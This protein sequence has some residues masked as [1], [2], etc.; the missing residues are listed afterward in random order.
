VD[1]AEGAALDAIGGI[2]GQEQPAAE[3][4]RQGSG[5]FGRVLVTLGALAGEDPEQIMEAVAGLTNLVDPAG[6]QQV[7]VD[8]RL[9]QLLGPLGGQVEQGPGHPGR[10]VGRVQHAQP[11]ERLLLE[12]REGA[13]AEGDAGPQLQVTRGELVQPPVLVGQPFHQPGQGPGRAGGQSRPGDSSASTRSPRRVR[14]S[15]SASG[16]GRRSRSRRRAPSRATR[17]RGCPGL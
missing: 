6:L 17:R 2:A 7:G 12:V 14:S 9:H 8:Q 10:E 16:S 5:P 15:S 4:P 13:V 3:R 1:E 11:P